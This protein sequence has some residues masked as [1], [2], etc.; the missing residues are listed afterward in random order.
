MKLLKSKWSKWRTIHIGHANYKAFA[1]QIKEHQNGKIKFRV[2][3]S[4]S[5]YGEPIT[6][7]D[8]TPSTSIEE[9]NI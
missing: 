5:Y 3:A 7:K 1:L 4:N 8:L 2:E 6:I 9:Q